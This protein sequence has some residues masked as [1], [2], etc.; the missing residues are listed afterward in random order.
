[1]HKCW[2]IPNWAVNTA[3]SGTQPHTHTTAA[4]NPR[5]WQHTTKKKRLEIRRLSHLRNAWW[6]F[7]SEKFS[8]HTDAAYYTVEKPNYMQL[9]TST[10]S[11]RVKKGRQPK[12]L[13]RI[14]NVWKC[15]DLCSECWE[16]ILWMQNETHQE[17]VRP[18]PTWWT[19][20]SLFFSGLSSFWVGHGHLAWIPTFF[21][22]IIIIIVVVVVVVVANWRG[23]IFRR[24]N[25]RQSSASLSF[26]IAAAAACVTS[27]KNE[28]GKMKLLCGK[29]QPILANK[30]SMRHIVCAAL[31]QCAFIFF[32]F[33]F[34]VVLLCSAHSFAHNFVY[35]SGVQ[36]AG[37]E[38]CT[39]RIVAAIRNDERTRWQARDSFQHT[40]EAHEH[41]TT[42]QQQ[43]PPVTALKKSFARCL[44]TC[45]RQIYA[46]HFFSIAL[47]LCYFPTSRAYS[48]QKKIK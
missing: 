40:E 18:L 11:E 22:M 33:F 3:S 47:P 8:L 30:N 10:V 12:F 27:E 44:W 17:C 26:F 48:T 41:T 5:T 4:T 39:M 7:F 38:M 29:K 23:Y 36:R 24:A 43:K 42:Q 15:R 35:C 16:N 46:V 37:M 21:S 6:R 34:F 13:A 1:M 2:N 45:S 20:S 19:L 31:S 9:I 32:L 14:K 28:N 25:F